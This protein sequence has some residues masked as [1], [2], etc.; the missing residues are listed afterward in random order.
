MIL[1]A[2]NTSQMTT[3]KNDPLQGGDI[4]LPSLPTGL[5]V[6]GTTPSAGSTLTSTSPISVTFDRPVSRENTEAS[7]SLFIG[8]YQLESNP[9]NYTRLGLTSMCN[10][11]WR[12][13]NP[14]NFSISFTWDIYKSPERGMGIAKA[15]GDT[16]FYTTR[17]SRTLR[18]FVNGQQQ[19][20]KA[21]NQ[22]A[23][24][25]NRTFTWNAESTKLSFGQSLEPGTYTL[26]I[27]TAASGEARLT[28]PYILNFTIASTTN[29]LTQEQLQGALDFIDS[30][31][32]YPG[33]SLSL[34]EATGYNT[35][36]NQVVVAAA[37]SDRRFVFAALSD[38]EVHTLLEFTE[39]SGNL[40]VKNVI[41]RRKVTLENFSQYF[42]ADGN[43]ISNPSEQLAEQ[44][45]P[46]FYTQ[47][48]LEMLDALNPEL[49]LLGLNAL[50]SVYE[51]L[52]SMSHRNG[53][54]IR[55]Q[56]FIPQTVCG[57]SLSGF[58][59]ALRAAAITTSEWGLVAFTA[60]RLLRQGRSWRE[61]I[62]E[63]FL[64]GTALGELALR[65]LG[66]DVYPNLV[67]EIQSLEQQLEANC[68][69]LNALVP[70]RVAMRPG[71]TKTVVA[72]FENPKS[73]VQP[74][75]LSATM[76]LDSIASLSPANISGSATPGDNS[77]TF[78]VRCNRQG[79]TTLAVRLLDP[80]AGYLI[81]GN[82]PRVYV[83]CDEWVALMGYWLSER[84]IPW[85]IFECEYDF[86]YA[87]PANNATYNILRIKVVERGP[88]VRCPRLFTVDDTAAMLGSALGLSGGVWG[89]RDARLGLPNSALRVYT[90][91]Q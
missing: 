54:Q 71:Q 44:I 35:A 27:S 36:E 61:V 76:N 83:V 85:G 90:L 47:S 45:M 80:N 73:Q 5:Q 55:R 58:Y 38:N 3:E 66:L 15:N 10:G 67:R 21:Q 86:T 40:T 84:Y 32:E 50:G 65:A 34:E 16:F 41:T 89:V 64:G 53:S 48:I 70:A 72:H 19:S 28:S 2:C 69:R 82:A 25:S 14:N 29:E 68:L 30:M 42:D 31:F 49:D 17:G 75:T 43:L 79:V 26:V 91:P 12:V 1:A 9:S 59:Q 22:T 20:V 24:T 87:T 74:F 18:L 6:V 23:C 56:N 4:Y 7:V 63:L 8:T 57:V 60:V 52:G 81:G 51:G 37:A 77:Q 78:E 13:R 88:S 39:E 33:V 11:Y 46:T 62:S